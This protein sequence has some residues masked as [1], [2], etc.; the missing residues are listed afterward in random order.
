M[1]YIYQNRF[2]YYLIFINIQNKLLPIL[3]II[4]IYSRNKLILDEIDYKLKLSDAVDYYDSED[5]IGYVRLS[6]IVLLF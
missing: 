2:P 6:I 1:E 3:Y 5:L 4:F